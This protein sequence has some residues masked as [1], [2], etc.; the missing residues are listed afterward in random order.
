MIS[1]LEHLPGLRQRKFLIAPLVACAFGLIHLP[2]LALVAA[3]CMLELAL[4]PLYQR[5]RNLWPLGVVHGWLGAF[6]YLWVLDRDLWA[7]QWDV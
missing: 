6:F 3:T 2:D 4:I 5:H 7:E 1:N